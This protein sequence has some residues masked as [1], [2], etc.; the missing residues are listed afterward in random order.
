LLTREQLRTYLG[1]V[2]D[3][4]LLRICPVAPLELGVRLV[5][6]NRRQIDEWL[7]ALPA[8]QSGGWP[9][10]NENSA[11]AASAATNPRT[12]IER[13]RARAARRA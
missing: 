11:D 12:A 1:G 3:E 13:A 4:T 2:S 6:W 7:D 10:A 9:S 8:R 5:R